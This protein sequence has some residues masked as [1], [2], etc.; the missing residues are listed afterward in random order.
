MGLSEKYAN[1]LKENNI[2]K[3]SDT[4]VEI[5]NYLDNGD[6]ENAFK[7]AHDSIVFGEAKAN[8]IKVEVARP[9]QIDEYMN[10][11]YHDLGL[12]DDAGN[13]S[14]EFTSSIANNRIN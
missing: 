5:L 2:D 12:T 14:D 10:D 8:K 3:S 4:L 9:I 1:W 7:K 6:T 13:L 11:I